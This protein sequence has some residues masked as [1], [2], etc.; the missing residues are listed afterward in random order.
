[1]PTMLRAAGDLVER[2]RSHDGEVIEVAD[3]VTE[4]TLTVLERTIFSDGIAGNRR[5]LRTAMRIYFDSLGRID[6][7]D[8][9]NLPD[10]VPRVG[11]LRTRAAV[12]L[13]HQGV[14]EM[15]AKPPPGCT[16]DSPAAG[17]ADADVKRA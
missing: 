8:L 17:P 15:I 12:R 7:F 3:Q 2:W 1:V 10:F 11:R 14:D 16:R 4:L 13:F 9:L 6:P 5:E